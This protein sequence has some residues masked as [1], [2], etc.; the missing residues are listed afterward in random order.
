MT[1]GRTDGRTDLGI[2]MEPVHPFPV[3]EIIGC[4]ML[5]ARC[6]LQVLSARGRSS[7]SV[8]VVVHHHH[9]LQASHIINGV[10]A[11]EERIF[12]GCFLGAAPSRVPKDIDVGAPECQS[13]VTFVVHSSGFTG[14]SLR[15]FVTQKLSNIMMMMTT[16]MM[17][18]DMDMDI[19]DQWHSKGR[20]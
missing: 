6:H 1:D 10:L 18:M 7:S 17:M 16:M 4:V 15:A 20:S 12:P 9:I 19:P 5:A 11:S 3:V 14:H 13:R 8:V 2:E